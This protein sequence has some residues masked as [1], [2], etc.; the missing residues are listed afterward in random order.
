M[1]LR[2]AGYAEMEPNS[3]ASR[4]LPRQDR[5]HGFGRLPRKKIVE[6]RIKLLAITLLVF[7]V[8]DKL[9]DQLGKVRCPF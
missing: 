4:K 1:H 3:L 5:L 2:I 9:E 7:F 8:Q 6:N